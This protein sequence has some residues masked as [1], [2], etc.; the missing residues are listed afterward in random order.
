MTYL[1]CSGHGSA[2]AGR[3]PVSRVVNPY[4]GLVVMRLPEVFPLRPYMRP[5]NPSVASELVTGISTALRPT[6][7]ATI[8]LTAAS[9]VG[10]PA[11]PLLVV[12]STRTATFLP[13]TFPAELLLMM[14]RV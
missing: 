5:V 7:A 1:F 12:V 13:S 8:A 4:R 9:A 2:D 14:A 6:I 3:L 10:G 11:S